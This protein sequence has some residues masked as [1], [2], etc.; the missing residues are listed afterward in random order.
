MKSLLGIV[1]IIVGIVALSNY[2]NLGRNGAETIGAFIGVG[3]FS[4]LPAIL[5][6]RSQ[7]KSDRN[8]K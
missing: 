8:E 2:P 4:F 6:F 3:L 7:N 5:L 1:L